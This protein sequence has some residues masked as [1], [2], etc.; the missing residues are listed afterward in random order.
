MFAL[1]AKNISDRWLRANVCRC[2]PILG[3]REQTRWEGIEQSCKE[4]LY[5]RSVAAQRRRQS[6]NI[7]GRTNGPIN[8]ENGFRDAF[9]PT[10]G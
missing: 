10:K 5:G 6:Q 9:T 8:Q 2:H 7:D 3:E 1:M 4:D